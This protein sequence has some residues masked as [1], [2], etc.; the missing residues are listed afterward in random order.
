MNYANIVKRA[1][2]LI[3]KASSSIKAAKV[4]IVN[5][6]DDTKDLHGLVIILAKHPKQTTQEPP[7]DK[8]SAS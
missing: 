3:D 5:F 1:N 2:K 4:H 8:I 6:G 7:P